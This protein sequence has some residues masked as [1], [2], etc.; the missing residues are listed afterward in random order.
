MVQRLC[1]IRGDEAII[2]L[3]GHASSDV[4]VAAAGVLVNITGFYAFYDDKLRENFTSNTEV[5]SKLSAVSLISVLRKSSMSDVLFLTL[6][7]QIFYNCL[8]NIKGLKSNDVTAA[9]IDTLDELVDVI[10]AGD[11]SSDENVGISRVQAF[12][13]A[14]DLVLNELNALSVVG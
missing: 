6:V 5:T 4:A 9:A 13:S 11:E 2:L 12:K 14:A 1:R 7:L 10:G 3:L 8:I